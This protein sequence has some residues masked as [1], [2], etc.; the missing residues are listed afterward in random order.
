MSNE[1]EI[2]LDLEENIGFSDEDAAQVQQK[3]LWYKGEKGRTD[4]VA[5]VNFSDVSKSALR[6][7]LRGNPKATVEEQRS[8]ITRT[9]RALAE[10]LGKS[11][12]DLTFGEQL[13]LR[14]VRF[15][16][17]KAAYHKELGFVEIPADATSTDEL[18]WRRV[19]EPRFY[20]YTILLV[21]RT[22]RDGD[23]D[24]EYSSKGWRLA[25]WRFAPEKLET[26]RRIDKG[27]REDGS[28]IAHVDL[29]LNC[30][31]TQYQKITITTAG[32]AYYRQDPG[33]QRQVLEAAA[34][35]S[36]RMKPFRQLDI[37][38]VR[39]KLGLAPPVVAPGSSA[40]DLDE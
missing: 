31:D 20:V 7:L 14:E 27:L 5:I 35:Q 2:S 16:Q 32:S 15:L 29:T 19:G 23:V 40:F 1:L 28:S 22:D 8:V 3:S 39:E 18:V 4:R 38:D 11:V 37:D 33:F 25:P 6:Q 12:R 10:K 30:T 9:K 34:V 17:A 26:L 36:Q 24:K 21:Y 13:D